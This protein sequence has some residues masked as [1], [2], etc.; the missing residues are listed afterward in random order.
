MN[1]KVKSGKEVL[2]DFFSNIESIDGVD[3]EIAE[4]LSTLYVMDKFTDRNVV[5]ALIDLRKEG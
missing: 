1:E 3:K 4:A 2:E 5:N